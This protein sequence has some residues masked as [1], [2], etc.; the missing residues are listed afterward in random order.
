VQT[1]FQL[2]GDYYACMLPHLHLS[3]PS[4][5]EVRDFSLLVDQL[6]KRN[7]ILYIPSFFPTLKTHMSQGLRY[8]NAWHQLSPA[9]VVLGDLHAL[10]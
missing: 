6:A 2:S 4:N 10:L 3:E 9:S 5:D 7:R 8:P 1:V